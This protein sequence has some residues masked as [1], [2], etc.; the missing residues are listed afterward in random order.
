MASGN[1]DD[2]Y[3][4]SDA[5]SVDD[6]PAALELTLAARVGLDSTR[7]A[8][9]LCAGAP[10]QR[11]GQDARQADGPHVEHIP[12]DRKQKR[13]RPRGRA[14]RLR[15]ARTC[16]LAPLMI[17]LHASDEAVEAVRF[18]GHHDP[19][20]SIGLVDGVVL[21]V[22]LLKLASLFI[23]APLP[24]VR[25]SGVRRELRAARISAGRSRLYMGFSGRS[26]N[27]PR[28]GVHGPRCR[29]NHE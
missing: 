9:G 8:R 16:L 27:R 11:Q 23:F 13:V 25:A 12:C 18:H 17:P 21:E 4:K 19:R 1:K 3:Q 10:E 7:E 22:E 26:R 20:K 24:C 6:L 2:E 15:N 28:D 5:Q 14:H 29:E